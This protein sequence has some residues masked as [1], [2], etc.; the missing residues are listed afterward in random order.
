MPQ[1]R[2]PQDPSIDTMSMRERPSTARARHVTPGL[3]LSREVP[4]FRV[5]APATN[6]RQG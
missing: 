6:L 3:R 5:D 1:I 4:G 2:R